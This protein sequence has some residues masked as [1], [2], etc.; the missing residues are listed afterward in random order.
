MTT[1]ST[2]NLWDAFG[3]KCI[4]CETQFK[5]YGAFRQFSGPVRT[6]SCFND[7]A[8]LRQMLNTP[9]SGEVLIVDGGGSLGAALIGDVTA[10]LGVKNGWAGVIIYGAIRDATQMMLVTLGVKALGTNP[11]TSTK[12]G[13]GEVDVSVSFGGVTFNPGN[14][15][16]SDED[17]TILSPTQ[18]Q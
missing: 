3:N 10:S 9:S 18:L 15:V 13:T 7:N 2:A 1:F 5:Q 16:Y 11:K 6:V 14:W 17:G 4:S 12:L 8:L